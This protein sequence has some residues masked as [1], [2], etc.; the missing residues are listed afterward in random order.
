MFHKINEDSF[1]YIKSNLLHIIKEKVFYWNG[2]IFGGFVRDTI[3]SEHYTY[4]FWKK[5]A[6]NKN[7]NIWNQNIDTDTSPRNLNSCNIDICMDNEEHATKMIQDITHVIIK[8]FNIYNVNI[9]N[10]FS[11]PSKYN[12]NNLPGKLYQYSYH[13]LVG[14]IPYISEGVYIKIN[15]DLLITSNTPPFGKLDFGC[16]GF[17]MTKQGI[18]LSYNTGTDIDNLNLAQHKELEYKIIKDITNFKTFYCIKFPELASTDEHTAI[19]YNEHACKRIEKMTTHKNKWNIENLPI[20]NHV[21]L[22]IIKRCFICSERIKKKNYRYSIPFKHECNNITSTL[23]VHHDCFFKSMYSQ[24]NEKKYIININNTNIINS[25]C[26]SAF[27]KCP[28][29][30]ILDFDVPNLKNIIAKYLEE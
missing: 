30:N 29:Q 22:N 15:I 1:N 2:I 7:V 18:S 5:Y 3:I 17:I 24:I 27:L 26:S 12:V 11:I 10:K 23:D 19:E 25:V 28:M 4:L 14:K 8:D 16:N 13:I 20:I 6:N 21:K 9:I